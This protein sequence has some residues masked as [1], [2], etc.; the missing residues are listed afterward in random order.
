MNQE[1]IAELVIS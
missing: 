1:T